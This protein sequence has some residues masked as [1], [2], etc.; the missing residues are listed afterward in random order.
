MVQPS[1]MGINN[2]LDTVEGRTR[3]FWGGVPTLTVYVD[4]DPSLPSHAKLGVKE[5]G[6]GSSRSFCFNAP[7][8]RACESAMI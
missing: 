3:K 1:G 7:L 2:E 5:N 8:R 6:R 4:Q